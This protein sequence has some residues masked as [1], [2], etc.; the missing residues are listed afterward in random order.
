M[1]LSILRRLEELA[2]RKATVYGRTLTDQEL[3]EFMQGLA[4][5][6]TERGMALAALD[7]ALPKENEKQGGGKDAD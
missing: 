2:A 6:H 4:E 1:G 5:K 3:A 7:G